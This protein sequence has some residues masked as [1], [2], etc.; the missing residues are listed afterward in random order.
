M[1]QARGDD[2]K[3]SVVVP[4]IASDD[5]YDRDPEVRKP[6]S[7]SALAVR[8]CSVLIRLHS[9]LPVQIWDLIVVGA[10]VAGSALAYKQGKV[11]FNG[12]IPLQ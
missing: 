8:C 6:L 4:T 5:Q 2:G 11:S 3:F 9:L 1:C 12:W 7:G 10:G